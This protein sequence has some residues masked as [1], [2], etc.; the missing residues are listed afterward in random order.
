M[1][2]R[3]KAQIIFFPWGLIRV[4]A[5]RILISFR[6]YRD[7]ITINTNG[8]LSVRAILRRE[9]LHG[10]CLHFSSKF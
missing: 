6:H 8:L 5:A 2:H 10:T 9:V 4:A 3:F 7:R 1:S